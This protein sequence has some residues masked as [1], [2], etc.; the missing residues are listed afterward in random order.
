MNS[1][2]KL[3]PNYKDNR[4]KVE[5]GDLITVSFS[6][7]L[8]WKVVNLFIPTKRHHSGLALWHGG[9]LFCA[10]LNP[11]S[12]SLIRH[13]QYTER[14]NQIEITPI[15]KKELG[16]SEADLELAILLYLRCRIT[17][18]YWQLGVATIDRK[19]GIV[20]PYDKNSQICSRWAARVLISVGIDLPLDRD[21]IDPDELVVLLEQI[22][23]TAE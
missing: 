17:Y 14:A 13:S 5:T 11:Q 16:I 20:L 2:Y 23:L 1:T 21:V 15:P 19:T 18:S 8:F 10:E 3:L 6:T 12:P 9:L 22:I 7:G 4:G